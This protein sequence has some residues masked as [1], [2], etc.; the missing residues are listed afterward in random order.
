MKMTYKE[1]K[2]NLT[3]QL[4]QNVSTGKDIKEKID[5]SS[6]TQSESLFNVIFQV[7][8]HL[9][10]NKKL[11]TAT[12][13]ELV[14]LG[15]AKSKAGWFLINNEIAKG[16]FINANAIFKTAYC[17]SKEC[18]KS[19]YQFMIDYRLENMKLRSGTIKPYEVGDGILHSIV[20][21][22]KGDREFV[23]DGAYY[24]VMDK[25]LYYSIFQFEDTQVLSR[26]TVMSDR[27]RLAQDNIISKPYLKENKKY[28]LVNPK[29]Y[30]NLSKRFSGMGFVIYLYNRD[31]FINKQTP[32]EQFEAENREALEQLNQKIQEIEGSDSFKF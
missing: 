12:I 20:T 30:A 18:H 14:K 15:V 21:F 26:Y 32:I 11:P 10:E 29:S 7:C 23:F 19:A 22:N 16:R 8:S 4:I 6:L 27:I 2:D 1:T 13:L 5:S 28:K 25:Q 24:V 9:Y 31:A 17:E 3:R